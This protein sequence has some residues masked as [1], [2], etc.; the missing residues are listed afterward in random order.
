MF[1]FF[2]IS[3]EEY[4]KITKYFWEMLDVNLYRKTPTFDILGCFNLC[5]FLQE[6]LFCNYFNAELVKYFNLYSPNYR[7]KEYFFL[8][9]YTNFITKYYQDK[10]NIYLK[11]V[12]YADYPFKSFYNFKDV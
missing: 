2:S 8:A 10:L 3:Q 7:N 9:P 11:K 6:A 1:N 12:M 4:F 5:N